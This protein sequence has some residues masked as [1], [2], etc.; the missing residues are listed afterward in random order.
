MFV[1][2][3]RPNSSTD[4]NEIL[5]RHCIRPRLDYR[6]FFRFFYFGNVTNNSRVKAGNGS[7]SNCI[8]VSTVLL[9]KLL[10]HSKLPSYSNEKDNGGGLY[11]SKILQLKLQATNFKLCRQWIRAKGHVSSKIYLAT[12]FKR[13]LRI[14]HVKRAW[15][16]C[17]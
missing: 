17:S 12:F 9:I 14:S 7:T 16:M 8:N 13:F 6:V 5:N 1:L 10:F 11:T 4:F 3:S 15:R 2:L